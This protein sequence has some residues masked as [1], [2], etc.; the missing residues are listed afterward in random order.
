MSGEKRKRGELLTEEK[1]TVKR[2]GNGISPMR[3]NEVVG[4]YAVQ[5]FNEEDLIQL[6][7]DILLN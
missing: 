6:A 4:T 7:D 1:L 2:P 3:W 5:S